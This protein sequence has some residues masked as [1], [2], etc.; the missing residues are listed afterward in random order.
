MLE[1]AGFRLTHDFID[2]GTEC[3]IVAAV[4]ALPPE[5]WDT[6]LRRRVLHFGHR[7]EYGRR[8]I[9]SGKGSTSLLFPAWLATLAE[10]LVT[11]G[12]F[13][14]HPDAAIVNEYAPGQGISHHVDA[15]VF[16]DTI[17]GISLLSA[18]VME[19]SHP[20]G[21]F[22]TID[23]PPRSLLILTGEARRVWRHAIPAR[24]SDP[25]PHGGSR[26]P[27]GRRLSVTLR[28]VLHC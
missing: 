4:D 25:D 12:A 21:A 16:G 7:Y 11:L 3:A 23:L 8:R 26:R 22:R 17:A 15:P 5:D 20:G 19:F 9:A 13:R 28:T 18:T 27:R 1:I 6:S 24:K 14:E 2:A 10:S